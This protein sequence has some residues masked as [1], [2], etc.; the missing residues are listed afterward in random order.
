MYS[1]LVAQSRLPSLALSREVKL[2]HFDSPMGS[3]STFQPRYS[4]NQAK[5]HSDSVM[6]AH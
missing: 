1:V 4:T 2:Q 5:S 3:I 6:S